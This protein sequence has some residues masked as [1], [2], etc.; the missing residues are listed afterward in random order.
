LVEAAAVLLAAEGPA[1][2]STRRLAAMVGASTSA[3]Y[4]RFGGMDGLV[5]AVVHEGFSRLHDRLALVAAT[6]DPVADLILLARAYRAA[7]RQ[8]PDLYAVMYG[9]AAVDG[10]SPNDDDRRLAQYTLSFLVA[11]VRRAM[12]ARRLRHADP[13]LL[14]RQLWISLHGLVTL[15]LGRY[16]ADPHDADTCHDAQ[17]RTFLLGAGDRAEGIDHSLTT[18]RRR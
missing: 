1:A 3:V 7:A 4:T 5:R 12:A 8:H 16:L 10:F 14:A 2:L 18:A 17:L 15:E 11:A 13:H 9:T 6:D